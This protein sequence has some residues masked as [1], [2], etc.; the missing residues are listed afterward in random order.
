MSEH[1]VGLTLKHLAQKL[2]EIGAEPFE[3]PDPK[4]NE[5]IFTWLDVTIT[6]K[7][8]ANE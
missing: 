3:S 7:L 2:D 8:E 6:I 1:V 4:P 5:L